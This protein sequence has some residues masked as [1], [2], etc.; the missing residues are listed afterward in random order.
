ML[1]TS[2][3][4]RFVNMAALACKGIEVDGTGLKFAMSDLTP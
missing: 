4:P 2:L 3:L 1:P